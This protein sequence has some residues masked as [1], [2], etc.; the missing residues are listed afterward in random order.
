MNMDINMGILTK[1]LIIL[2]IIYALFFGCIIFLLF[3][4]YYYKKKEAGMLITTIKRPFD[5]LC[6][7]IG[8]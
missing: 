6:K 3:Y 8:S 1:Y 2:S 5:V 4:R 7:K